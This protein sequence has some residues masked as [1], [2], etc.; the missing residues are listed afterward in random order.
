MAFQPN[1]V[2]AV[3]KIQNFALVVAVSKEAP[4]VKPHSGAQAAGWGK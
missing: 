3:I 2:V 4:D 1:K